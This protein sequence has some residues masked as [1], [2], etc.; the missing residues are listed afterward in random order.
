MRG[1]KEAG[2]LTAKTLTVE[3]EV[4]ERLG[5]KLATPEIVW[6]SKEPLLSA[7]F[8]RAGPSWRLATG[9][10]DNDVKVKLFNT[11]HSTPNYDTCRSEVPMHEYIVDIILSHTVLYCYGLVCHPGMMSTI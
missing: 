10:A 9:G 3:L 1:G 4:H 11:S 7:D 8:H 5:M 6:H 2:K